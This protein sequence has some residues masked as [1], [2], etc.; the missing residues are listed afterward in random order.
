MEKLTR[1]FVLSALEAQRV[2][3]FSNS[4][5]YRL[6]ADYPDHNKED[7]IIAKTMIIGRVYA[8]QLERRNEAGEVSSD[9]FY[10]KV[11]K[12]F[13]KSDIDKWLRDL[14]TQSPADQL[15]PIKVHRKLVDL[16]K[17]LTGSENRSFASKY[18]HFHHPERFFHL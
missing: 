13:L 7:V 9:A 3:D 11:A 10:L 17:P 4:V 18:L 1:E 8:A 6:C 12:E 5:L 2:W 14:S 15:L 16:T